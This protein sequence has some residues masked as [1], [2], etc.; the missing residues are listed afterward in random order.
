MYLKRII[1]EEMIMVKSLTAFTLEIDDVEFAVSEIE[2]QLGLP[3]NL[4]ENSVGLISCIPEFIETGVVRAIAEALPFPIV[5]T[6]TIATVAPGSED[7]SGLSILVITG[8]EIDFVVGTTD[9]IAGED[10][11]VILDAY[12]AAASAR[13]DEPALMISYAPLLMNVGG[14]FFVTAITKASG[15]VPNFGTL[16][17]DDTNDYHLSRTLSGGE[18]YADRM[19]FV[20]VYG[21]IKPRYYLA[22]LSAEK[23]FREKGVVTAAQGNQLQTINNVSVAEYL[24]SLGL[25]TDAEGNIVGVNSFPY[26]VDYNDG[27]EPVVRV[28]F[29]ITPEGYAVC[30]GDIPVGATLSVG[31]FDGDEI[32]RATSAK[33]EEIKNDPAPNVVLIFSCI[34]RYLSLG[35]EPDVE[36]DKVKEV[37]E[38]VGVPYTMTYSGGELCPV[39]G[40]NVAHGD[41]SAQT[42]ASDKIPPAAKLATTNRFHNS[43]FIACVF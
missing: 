33:L 5:G 32:V 18:D 41:G 24:K 3:G 30:G 13:M 31:R 7:S 21:D 36:G 16:S 38:G 25:T 42:D 4:L 27:T 28:V 8:D 40:T 39:Y 12:R 1:K 6:T 26:I 20:L 2:E 17:V 37:L 14:D 34:G 11:D 9:P 29:A 15:G 43:T 23:V 22:T 10:A 19:V 35:Y